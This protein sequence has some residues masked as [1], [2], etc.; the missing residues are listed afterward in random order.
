MLPHR[1]RISALGNTLEGAEG[2]AFEGNGAEGG[3][4]EGSVPEE[5]AAHAQAFTHTDCARDCASGSACLPAWEV[6]R[7]AQLAFENE[8]W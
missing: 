3:A 2:S 4:L 8:G 5:G 1:W 7:L 6:L